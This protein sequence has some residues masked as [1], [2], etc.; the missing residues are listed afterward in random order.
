MEESSSHSP[1]G[2]QKE[3][4]RPTR[5]GKKEWRKDI[6][7]YFFG[8]LWKV[9]ESPNP[10]AHR[11][12]PGDREPF[13]F[14][15]RS[16]QARRNVWALLKVPGA[17]RPPWLEDD[18]PVPV[19]FPVL[20]LVDVPGDPLA[21][22]ELEGTR[23]KCAGTSGRGI[24]L[25]FDP[26]FT[27]DYNL[28]EVQSSLWR[29]FTWKTSIRSGML[30]HRFRRYL[31]H[32]AV[33]QRQEAVPQE[34]TGPD[35]VSKGQEALRWLIRE[36]LRATGVG[37]TEARALWPEGR[38]H[39]VCVTHETAGPLN[40]GWVE[41]LAGLEQKR[42]LC[43]TWFLPGE[44]SLQRY[45]D[46]PEQI[47]SCGHEIGLL[48]DVSSP[49]LVFSSDISMRHAM[50][51]CRAFIERWGVR[52]F[53]SSVL[54]SSPVLKK[55]LNENGLYDSSVTDFD[56]LYP[57]EP[58]RGCGSVHPFELNG[59]LAIPVTL[60]APD[61]LMAAGLSPDEIVSVWKKKLAWVKGVG[62]AAVL[63]VCHSRKLTSPTGK[64]GLFQWLDLY[65]S[66]L[67]GMAGDSDAWKATLGDV[68][69]RCG[70]EQVIVG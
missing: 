68:A 48:G 7:A 46:L 35:F 19:F 38:T 29:P 1:D 20:Y 57:T 56:P 31:E 60:P 24:R 40:R 61:R 67:D 12:D 28:A 64:P 15:E 52:G 55:V 37:N 10:Y 3:K 47:R 36:A 43:S 30:H 53:R 17:H 14:M 50:D 13:F 8:T 32:R 49:P 41:E 58:V 42:G 9:G 23:Y 44:R 6:E 62:G 5:Y 34:G 27:I 2:Q 69:E 25:S 18:E 70:K 45:G 4:E 65:E 66:F 59:S 16:G 63:R 22:V 54:L 11:A 51:R 26:V 39:A 33:R 21:F